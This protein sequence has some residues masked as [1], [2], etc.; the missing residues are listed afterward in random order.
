M[1]LFDIGADAADVVVQRDAATAR[2]AASEVHIGGDGEPD[3]DD[4]GVGGDDHTD[5]VRPS[6]PSPAPNCPC[7]F[8][9][10]APDAA[11]A[12]DAH[13]DEA[14]TTETAAS[15]AGDPVADDATAG[16]DEAV[17]AAIYADG[18]DLPGD[19][20]RGEASDDS[21]QRRDSADMD[22]GAEDRAAY[23]RAGGCGAR[24][25]GAAT[26]RAAASDVRAVASEMRAAAS[27]VRTAVLET[28]TAP[29]EARAVAA[30]ARAVAA[31]AR[32]AEL[33][34]QKD[35]AEARI[36]AERQAPVDAASCAVCSAPR[37]IS[38]FC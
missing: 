11:A 2:A 37:T 13:C 24:A 34:V 38:F 1:P 16:D 35:A 21:A 4:A 32:A 5:A 3:E 18:D 9:A 17:G 31:E 8:A 30:E 10:G 14:A 28:R 22:V 7:A 27:E 23:A 36:V 25:F 6:E 12:A 20:G 29:L 15:T 26:A 33:S 19:D